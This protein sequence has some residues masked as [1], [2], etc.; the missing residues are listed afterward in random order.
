MII[1]YKTKTGEVVGTIDGRVH[2]KEHLK[3][4]VG[5]KDKISRIVYNWEKGKS[6]KYRPKTK[7]LKQREILKFLDKKPGDVYNFKVDIKSKKLIKGKR[8]KFKKKSQE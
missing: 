1:F 7:D 2:G 5:K 3:M 4:W 6:G 8:V